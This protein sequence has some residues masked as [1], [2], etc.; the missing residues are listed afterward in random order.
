MASGQNKSEFKCPVPA[1]W[2]EE[3]EE[4]VRDACHEV[5]ANGVLDGVLRM[6]IPQWRDISVD[7]E[8]T[9]VNQ[10]DLETVQRLEKEIE[11]LKQQQREIQKDSLNSF[12]NVMEELTT[13][14]DKEIEEFNGGGHLPDETLDLLNRIET[15][16]NSVQSSFA[17]YKEM[18][19]PMDLIDRTQA[20]IKEI[21]DRAGSVKA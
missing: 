16:M 1:D 20:V 4:A 9:V 6:M 2:L 5:G 12:G 17:E 19:D 10:E 11:E 18:P 7:E 14:S 15:K 21:T 3:Y 8:E 13:A